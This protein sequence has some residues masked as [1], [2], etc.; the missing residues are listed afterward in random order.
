MIQPNTTNLVRPRTVMQETTRLTKKRKR[1][2]FVVLSLCGATMFLFILSGCLITSLILIGKN[3]SSKTVSA[4]NLMSSKHQQQ[5]HN[6]TEEDSDAFRDLSEPDKQVNY[7]TNTISKLNVSHNNKSEVILKNNLFEMATISKVIDKLTFRL[8]REIIPKFY[9]LILNPDLDTK[10]FTGNVS[11]HLDI[12]KATDFI[13]VHSKGLIITKTEL[14]TKVTNDNQTKYNNIDIA[15]TFE[16]PKYEFW[17]TEL[18]K[19]VPIGKYILNLSFNGNMANRTSGLYQS[20]YLDTTRNI[21][22]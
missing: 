22:R 15:N 10:L 2:S 1:H 4:A 16:Y 13:V 7:K 20:T 8:S 21:Q 6:S 18:N 14:Q 5:Y 17:V 3:L 19:P 9:D 11:I 12:L